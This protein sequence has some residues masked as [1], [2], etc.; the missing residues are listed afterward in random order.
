MVFRSDHGGKTRAELLAE[1]SLLQEALE[2]ISDAFVVSDNEAQV[3][4][5][6][7]TIRHALP[8]TS[9]Q[10]T[11]GVNRTACHQ[12]RVEQ[13]PNNGHSIGLDE[14]K[15]A[16]TALQA[17]EERY[18]QLAAGSIM[19]IGIIQDSRFVFINPSM[20]QLLGYQV[21]EVI[22]FAANEFVAS[23]HHDMVNEHHCK[24]MRGEGCPK[25]YEHLALH[26]DGSRIWV[27]QLT[28]VVTWQGR[29]ATQVT[30]SDIH[31]R[32]RAN[33][34]LVAS[35][36]RLRRLT[37]ASFEGVFLHARG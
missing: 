6:N 25:S 21:D 7:E 32:K 8:A 31:E 22:G 3:S 10:R 11:R 1:I 37:E 23:E 4:S 20:A 12:T 33:E 29:P 36:G 15:L 13:Q 34:A 18:R 28:Q 9:G 14:L 30:A 5:H 19:G 2:S 27:E 26:K 24:L 16:E 17:S 35:E